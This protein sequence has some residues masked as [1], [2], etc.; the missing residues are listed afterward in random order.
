VKAAPTLLPAGNTLYLVA[1]KTD[2]WSLDTSLV[3]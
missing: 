2:L 1:D 3:R